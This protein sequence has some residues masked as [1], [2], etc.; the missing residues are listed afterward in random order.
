MEQRGL[1][2]D[3]HL[4]P[5]EFASTLKSNEALLITRAY[6]RVRYGREKLSVTEKRE[7]EKALFA[8]EAAKDPPQ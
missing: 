1:L 8:L 7:V 5:L 6:N 2:R 4:T 3:Q